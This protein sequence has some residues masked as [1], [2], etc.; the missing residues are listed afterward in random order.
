MSERGV[1]GILALWIVTGASALAFAAVEMAMRHQ[2]RESIQI[3]EVQALYLAYA[4]TQLARVRD[5]A[6]ESKDYVFETGTVTTTASAPG[7]DGLLHFALQVRCGSLEKKFDTGWR[8]VS[9][10]WESLYWREP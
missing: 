6:A 9:G 2:A 1:V 8:R 7:N 3:Q 4:A 10:Q 5:F